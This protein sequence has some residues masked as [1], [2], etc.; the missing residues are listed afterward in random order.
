MLLPITRRLSLIPITKKYPFPT[1]VLQRAF[2]STVTDTSDLKIVG[3]EGKNRVIV[4]GTGWAGFNLALH[5]SKD[6]DTIPEIRVVSPSNHFVFTPLL[7]STAVG[8]LEFRCIQEPIRKVLGENGNFVQAKARSVDPTTRTL[9]CQS[10]HDKEEFA[11][12][13]DKLVIA[14]GVKTNNFGIDSIREGGGIY[15]LKH[16]Y[17]AR[18]IRNNIIDSFEKAAI[19]GTPDEERNR[20]LSFIVVGGGPTSCEFVAELHDFVKSDI[21]KLYPELVPHVKV[22][23][24]EAGKA[25]LGPFDKKLQNY[26]QGLFETRDIDVRLGCSVTSVEDYEGENFRFS[27]RRAVLSDDTKLPFGTLVWSAGLKSVNFLHFDETMPKARNGRLLVDDYLRVKGFE[28]SIWAMGDAAEHEKEPLPQLAQVARQ[29]AVYLSNI[30]NGNAKEDESPFRFFSLGSMASVG[31][32]KGLYDGSK[33][34]MKGEE[35][36]VPGMTGFFALL[37]WRF[38]YW[39]NQTSIE[40]K[41]LIPMHWLKSFFFGRDISRF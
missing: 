8:T 41:V 28:G 6:S 31:D 14:V 33:V 23:L 40:N 20:L 3:G 24:V 37:M 9:I 4:L 39:G 17:H 36:S 22:T 38:A 34:G 1:S 5:M 26:T 29:Q 30:L 25:L 18:N 19:P 7:P 32:M 13:Y 12:K 15:F 21:R 16:L 11:I 35:I 2:L 10:T 27:G